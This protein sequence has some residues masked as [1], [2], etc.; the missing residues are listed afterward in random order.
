MFVLLNF[1]YILWLLLRHMVVFLSIK[2]FYIGKKSDSYNITLQKLGQKLCIVLPIAGPAFIKL[3]QFLSA[4]ADLVDHI[5]CNELKSLH[6]QAPKIAFN[7]IKSILISELGEKFTSGIITVDT[8]PIAAA[9]IAQVH[10]GKILDG[11]G[12]TSVAVKILRPNIKK[13]FKCNINLIKSVAKIIDKL[14]TPAKR[15]RLLEVVDVIINT[16]KIE[17]DMKLEAAVADKMRYNTAKHQYAYIPKIFWEYTTTQVLVMEWIDGV[18]IDASEML[19]CFDT[20]RIAKDLAFTVFQQTY[21][22]GFFHADIHPGNI[23]I[24]PEGKVALIDFGLVSYLPEKDRLFIAKIIFA[25]I[26]RDYEK[27]A[28]LHFKAGYVPTNNKHQNPIEMFALACRSLIEPIINKPLA[29]ISIGKLLRRLFEITSEFNMHT[30]PQ[31]LLLQKNMV[32][33]EG[34]LFTIDQ[35]VNMWELTEPWFTEWANEHLGTMATIKR[36][37]HT[38]IKIIERLI[39]STIDKKNIDCN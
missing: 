21:T 24:T 20:K 13:D 4:R 25:L 10:K 33:L 9:S 38:A 23:L 2:A 17:L 31:L 26:K 15:L 19:E 3:G 14:I 8:Q 5:I 16:V 32:T 35:T 7:K 27:V 18:K 12:E 37:S 29:E 6:D 28:E 1:I 39:I 11:N 34:T 22:D 36:Q 30:Q